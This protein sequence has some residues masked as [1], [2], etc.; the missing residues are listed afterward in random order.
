MGLATGQVTTAQTCH[1]G[2]FP[3]Y[4]SFFHP[5]CSLDRECI[6]PFPLPA[7]LGALSFTFFVLLSS[8]FP[9]SSTLVYCWPLDR[10]VVSWPL[11]L[12]RPPHLRRPCE[13]PIPPMKRSRSRRSRKLGTAFAEDDITATSTS[14]SDEQGDATYETD[15]TEADDSPSPRKR[16]RS[17]ENCSALELGLPGEFGEYYNDPLDDDGIDLSE[18]P[19]DFDKAPGT[20][21]RRERI[22]TRW[23]RLPNEPKWREPEEALRQASNNDMY[24]FLGWCL[25]LERGKNNRRLKRINKASSLNT[26]WKNLRG[27]Y[28]KLTKIKINDEDGSDVRRGMKYLVQEHGLDTQP[29][30]KT[31]VYIEDIGPFNETILILTYLGVPVQL[32]RFVHCAPEERFVET[33]FALPEIVYGPSLV[34][35]PYTLLFGILFHARAF[36]NS[37]L[38]SK[39]QLRKLFI[40]KGYPNKSDWYIFCKTELVNGVPTIQRTVQMSKSAMS[41]LLVTFGEI[42]GWKGAF[43]A[44]QFRYRSGKVI[45]ESGWVSKEQHM[46]IMKHASPWTFLDHYHLDLAPTRG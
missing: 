33:T 30:K 2:P 31:L 11:S 26:D 13:P 38:T 34:I 27:Y 14:D 6:P 45:N 10:I 35:C 18:I 17:D 1:R 44:H 12:P 41:T 22:E 28:Q 40:S 32:T 9:V 4:S 21:E 3:L 37:R 16:L 24:R 20:I 7:Y 15:L 23:K 19:E 46:L 42:R 25:K 8:A 5:S 36:R 43:H 39:A 29:G